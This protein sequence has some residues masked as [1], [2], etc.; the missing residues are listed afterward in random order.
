[1]L[2]IRKLLLVML[3]FGTAPFTVACS[4]NTLTYSTSLRHTGTPEIFRYAA[5]G[6]DLETIVLGNPTSAPKSKLERAVLSAVQGV[7]FG[8]DTNFTTIPSSNARPGY[9]LVILI[10]GDSWLSGAKAC[11]KA[12]TTI[13]PT[14]QAEAVSF[15]AEGQ[16]KLQAAFCYRDR[17]LSEARVK[18][19]EIASPEDPAL[20]N[21][22][23]Q[24]VLALLPQ[25]DPERHPQGDR[26]RFR[27]S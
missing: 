15:D 21:A 8:P 13:N 22:V 9:R 11:N 6:R 27:H 18:M 19:R 1:M 23:R 10:S 5:S 3:A 16:V 24:A 26:E 25:R 17:V 14:T 12:E 4:K 20:R 2:N 7:P